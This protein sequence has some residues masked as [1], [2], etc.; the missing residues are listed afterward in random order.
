[1]SQQNW[2]VRAEDPLKLSAEYLHCTAAFPSCEDDTEYQQ[3]WSKQKEKVEITMNGV[4]RGEDFVAAGV[5]LMS[6]YEVP[7]SVPHCSL[8]KAPEKHWK[9]VGI[10]MKKVMEATD[11]VAWEG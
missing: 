10:W 11:W 9:D 2:A 5:L 8:S 7:G 1:M 3:R 4:Y 6:L